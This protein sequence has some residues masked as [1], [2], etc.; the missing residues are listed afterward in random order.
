MVLTLNKLISDPK[1]LPS[2]MTSS[3]Q[4]STEHDV[5]VKLQIFSIFLQKSFG[6]L[7]CTILKDN[8]YGTK[9]ILSVDKTVG[10]EKLA[11]LVLRISFK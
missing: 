5:Q 9:Y 4:T 6:H 10:L 11:K 7:F 8:T 2:D 1:F 3:T